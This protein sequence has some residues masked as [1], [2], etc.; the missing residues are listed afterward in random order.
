MVNKRAAA[1]G[2]LSVFGVIGI[3]AGIILIPLLTSV[4]AY[5]MGN[6]ICGIILAL[7][8]LALLGVL[9]YLTYH[10]VYKMVDN[11]SRRY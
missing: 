1:I 11:R 9:C 10:G 8:L 6:I 2:G 7:M 5:Q 3:I 4:T